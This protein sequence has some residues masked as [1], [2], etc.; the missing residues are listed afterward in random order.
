MP[1]PFENAEKNAQQFMAG[2]HT[3]YEMLKSI[4]EYKYAQEMIEKCS[5]HNDLKPGIVDFQAEIDEIESYWLK[6]ASIY[7]EIGIMES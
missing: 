2:I 7:S 1:T 4:E 5:L 6:V 3:M